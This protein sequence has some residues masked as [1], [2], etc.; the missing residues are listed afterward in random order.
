M[1]KIHITLINASSKNNTIHYRNA[2]KIKEWTSLGFDVSMISISSDNL[3]I[4]DIFIADRIPNNIFYWGPFFGIT[5]NPLVVQQ[6]QISL[7]SQLTSPSFGHLGDHPFAEW[8]MEALDGVA[9]LDCFTLSGREKYFVKDLDCFSKREYFKYFPL[10]EACPYRITEPSSKINKEELTL[11]AMDFRYLKD[12]NA[13]IEQGAR[14]LGLNKFR[15]KELMEYLST[16]DLYITDAIQAYIKEK[17]SRYKFSEIDKD[18]L[19]RATGKLFHLIDMKYRYSTRVN[20]FNEYCELFPHQH[21]LV[22]GNKMPGLKPNKNTEFVGNLVFED[23][24]KLLDVAKTT[25]FANPTY[26]NVVNE[27]IFAA[28]QRNVDIIC[29]E[30]KAIHNVLGGP[31][32]YLN[33]HLIKIKS[34]DPRILSRAMSM[35]TVIEKLAKKFKSMMC[36]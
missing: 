30:N 7:I 27:R 5:I 35:E 12:I 6:N 29:D 25:L 23:Y 36:Q 33:D 20:I 34:D 31:S 3:F 13:I 14:N 15:I 28:L 19:A 16:S 2:Q 10:D 24:L 18:V 11:V 4:R 21:I 9:N 32:T 22:L 26:P 1:P 17:K 8:M